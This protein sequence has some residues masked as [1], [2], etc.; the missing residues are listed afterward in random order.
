MAL[1]EFL[2]IVSS[3][4]QFLIQFYEVQFYFFPECIIL[5]NSGVSLKGHSSLK[6][7]QEES[8]AD[9]GKFTVKG[10]AS[11]PSVLAEILSCDINIETLMPDG[12]KHTLTA[13]GDLLTVGVNNVKTSAPIQGSYDSYGLESSYW[14]K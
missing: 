5:F 7:V 10:S 11:I 9:S 13:S 1:Q 14:Q 6:L 4:I 3:C 2:D 12:S 8:N